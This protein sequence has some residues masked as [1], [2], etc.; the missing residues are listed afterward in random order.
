MVVRYQDNSPNDDREIVSSIIHYNDVIM[1]AMASQI[2]ST[3]TVCSTVCSGADQ[4]KHHSSASQA[5]VRGSHRWPVNSPHKGPVTRKMLPFDDVISR[6]TATDTLIHGKLQRLYYPKAWLAIQH[7]SRIK[8]G[9]VHFKERINESTVESWRYALQ[10]MEASWVFYDS[11]FVGVVTQITLQR[12]TGSGC[13]AA[14]TA[15]Y[16]RI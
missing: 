8:L 13:L 10:C 11:N 4:G 12:R 15:R 3:S 1:S 6:D 2:T 7:W 14:L 5:F 9:G 16:G